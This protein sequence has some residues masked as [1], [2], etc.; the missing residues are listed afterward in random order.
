MKTRTFLTR[1]EEET[2]ALAAQLAREWPVPCCVVLSGNL[3]AGKTTFAKGVAEGLG[4][5]PPDEISSPT[6]ALIHEHGG[7]RLYHV[8]LYRLDTEAEAASLGLD[9]ILA[10]P[11][12]VLLEWAEKFP[13][14]LPEERI[15]IRIEPQADES[16]LIHVT[17]LP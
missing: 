6:F 11:A 10:Q 5:A 12:V 7:G 16:R 13:A 9:E 3:G 14:L 4:A 8:D 1:T 2:I 15:E 17:E